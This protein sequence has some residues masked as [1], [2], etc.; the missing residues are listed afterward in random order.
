MKSINI[1]KDSFGNFEIL[2]YEEQNS[3]YEGMVIQLAS[4]NKIV[5]SR[6]AK[7]T[8]KK[9]GYFVAFWEKDN[10]NI[11]QPFSDLD[12]PEALVILIDDEGKQGIFFIPKE[13]AVKNRILSNENQ[14]GKMAM[15]FYPSWCKNLNSTAQK[16]QSWQLNYFKEY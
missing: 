9:D 14:K 13:V 4:N 3:E 8:P 1:L 6:L 11:N 5:R 7:K 16:T 2:N 12:T 15:R 10:L